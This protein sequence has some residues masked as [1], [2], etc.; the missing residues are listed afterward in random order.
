[1]PKSHK[2]QIHVFPQ[3]FGGTVPTLSS[4]QPCCLLSNVVSSGV[5]FLFYLYEYLFVYSETLG[6]FRFVGYVNSGERDV[7]QR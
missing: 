3:L 2:M 1:M 5:R 6:I 4:Y 7:A